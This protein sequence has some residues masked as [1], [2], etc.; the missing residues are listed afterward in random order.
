MNT[1]NYNQINTESLATKIISFVVRLKGKRETGFEPYA[2]LTNTVK[3][4]VLSTSDLCAHNC[5]HI[6]SFILINS[7]KFKST[8]WDLSTNS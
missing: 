8:Y 4:G 5:A 6:F 2:Y 7:F 3:K 1:C